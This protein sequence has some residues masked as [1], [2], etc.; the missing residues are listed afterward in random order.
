MA[1]IEPMLSIP[2]NANYLLIFS[3]QDAENQ[4]HPNKWRL[5]PDCQDYF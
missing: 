5:R 1:E 4:R 3:T 2:Q